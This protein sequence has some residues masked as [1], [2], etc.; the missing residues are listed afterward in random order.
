MTRSQRVPAIVVQAIC[1]RMRSRLPLA[2]GRLSLL[3]RPPITPI[4][5]PTGHCS[6][7]E[8]PLQLSSGQWRTPG[9]SS[10]ST[11]HGGHAA[12]RGAPVATTI[13]VRCIRN[14]HER[15]QRIEALH[16]VPAR[17]VD[18]PISRCCIKQAAVWQIMPIASGGRRGS[19]S[20]SPIVI[21][22]V[23]S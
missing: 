23:Q 18:R 3:S 20:A 2:L 4:R 5:E 12:S 1:H 10:P 19:E 6:T 7:R 14:S 17:N 13:S 16:A 8:R 22:S 21:R 15:E 9:A 11:T